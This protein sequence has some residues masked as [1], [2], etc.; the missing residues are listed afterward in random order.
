MT[1]SSPLL[2]MKKFDEIVHRFTAWHNGGHADWESVMWECMQLDPDMELH[3]FRTM[4]EQYL[5]E[6]H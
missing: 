3:E 1:F 4:L 2:T 5:Q 6:K